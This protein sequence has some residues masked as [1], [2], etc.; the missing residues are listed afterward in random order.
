[1]I[2]SFFYL[3]ENAQSHLLHGQH[4]LA[5]MLLS[6][7][8]AVL[9]SCF[10]LQVASLARIA[11]TPLT[12]NIALLTGSLTLGGGIW[13]MHFIGM[14]AFQLEIPVRYD[15]TI[16]LLSVVPAI[17]ASWIAFRVLVEAQV[18][19]R[20]I[21]V[22][23]LLMG[24]GI[25]AMHY[26]GMA[27]MQMEA[28]LMMDPGWFLASLLVAVMLAM[29]ALW[30]R[31]GLR[32]HMRVTHINSIVLGGLGIGLAIAAMHYTGMAAARIVA[33]TDGSAGVA[34]GDQRIMAMGIALMALAVGL[35]VGVTNGILRY[36]YLLDKMRA[37]EQSL[38]T[39]EE[40]YSSLI[41]NL[42]GAAFR[43][44]PQQGWQMLFISD[45]IE[46]LTGWSAQAFMQG[47]KSTDELLHP[48]DHDPI[49]EQ[50]MAHI[51]RGEKYSVDY[52]LIHRDGSIRWVNESASAI[53]S[54][55][56]QPLW[57]DGVL[58]DITD[59]KL[60][61]A[62]FEG[63]VNAISRAQAVAEFDLHGRITA[64]NAQLLNL[65]GFTEAE[66]IGQPATSLVDAGEAFPMLWEELR[67][68]HFQQA[69]FPLHTAHGEE[70]WI[71]GYFNPI[72]MA[73]GLPG[74]VM[75]LATDL[76]ER[77]RMV[78]ALRLAK[79]RAEQAAAA[80][81]V[82][83]ANMSHEIRTPMNAIMGFS[84]LLLD[85]P[86]NEEQRRHLQTLNFSAQALLQLLNDI[87]DTAKLEGGAV[88][89]DEQPFSPR[90]LAQGAL[91]LMSLE[92]AKKDLRL[93]LDNE[94][95][96]AHFIGDPFRI[97]Q[98]LLNL[99]GNAIKFTPSGRVSLHLYH[100][101][102]GLCFSVSDTGIGISA[103]RLE[104]IFD[105]FVQADASMTRRFGGT[106]LGT[107]IARQLARLMGGDIQV[108]SEPGTGSCFTLCIP[109]HID[110]NTRSTHQPD[111]LEAEQTESKQSRNPLERASSEQHLQ[112][113]IASLERGEI[114]ETHVQALARLLPR[115]RWLPIEQALADFD[116]ELANRHM[117]D[118]L[119]EDTT[120]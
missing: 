55:Q 39:S 67:A 50:V 101:E 9:A 32:R 65:S 77:R 63:T 48:D 66:L 76:T 1:M 23:G 41:A 91:D 64:A 111:R 27:A 106:G 45:A 73:D 40:Q 47:G 6:V 36:R 115:S 71:Q 99:L 81:T 117:Q 110:R 116:F 43:C 68:G 29:V 75:L 4:D 102:Q 12:R 58:I 70:R 42:P 54:E 114:A 24:G 25:G 97:R 10:A 19:L 22:G 93:Q 112:A 38:R 103:E 37:H 86:L 79:E 56:G 83:L 104:R 49:Y 98:I 16:T 82:F 85:T 60:R 78:L 92:A 118:L 35:A 17:L 84:E 2:P 15:P 57:I 52:R 44:L 109:L 8:I 46:P 107:T 5:L 51:A 7:V 21:A 96:P 13:A 90:E 31:F 105:P 69:E 87:L 61:N 74:K 88:E 14:L 62:E 120:P 80:K 28:R 113:L 20:Q 18:T 95:P 33:V 3:P 34:T 11:A 72:L 100:N 26:T 30:L 94:L 53:Y 108:Q 119:N 89:L 59:S